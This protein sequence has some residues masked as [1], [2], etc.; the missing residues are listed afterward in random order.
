MRVTSATGEA[1]AMP[2]A[3]DIAAIEA[4]GRVRDALTELH[5]YVHALYAELQR[6]EHRV[7]TLPG[8]RGQTN[9]GDELRR[10]RTVLAAQL[11]LLDRMILA[12]RAAADPTGQLL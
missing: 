4:R 2:C 6:V 1:W 8:S 5:A 10:R 7:A 11:E 3:S 12:L 9:E